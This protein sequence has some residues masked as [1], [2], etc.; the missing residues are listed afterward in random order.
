MSKKDK[1]LGD[2]MPTLL[3]KCHSSN[4]MPLNRV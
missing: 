4:E 3:N 2:D 1:S